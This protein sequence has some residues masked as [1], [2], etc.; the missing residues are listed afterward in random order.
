MLDHCLLDRAF[1][2][3]HL[4]I[5]PWMAD[6]GEPMFNTKCV[7]N[8]VKGNIPI[9]FHPLA[10]CKLDAVISQ[11]CVNG[12]RHGRDQI[13]EERFRDHPCGLGMKFCIGKL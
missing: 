12:V 11:D 1:H 7:A 5:G 4:S 3:F 6:L 8:P 13:V 9:R 2:A 10:F